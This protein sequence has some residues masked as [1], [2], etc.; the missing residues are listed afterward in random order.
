MKSGKH[1]EGWQGE[2]LVNLHLVSSGTF[3]VH[4]ARD[5]ETRILLHWRASLS[6]FIVG[7]YEKDV[8][9]YFLY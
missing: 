9:C 8:L 7:K 4:G 6:L 3:S 5:E 2:A 1:T